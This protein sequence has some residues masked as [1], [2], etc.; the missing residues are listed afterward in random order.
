MAKSG[1]GNPMNSEKTSEHQP[2][3]VICKYCRSKKTRKYGIVEG[4][5]RYYCNDCKR[6]FSPN[7]QTFRMKTPVNQVAFALESYYEGFSINKVRRLLDE[8]YENYPSSKTV[9]R[10]ITKYTLEA[11]KQFRDYYLQVG[12]LWELHKTTVNIGSIEYECLDVVDI[13]TGYLLASKLILNS[14]KNNLKEIVG[15][16]RA[17]AGK[18]AVTILNES[19][20]GQSLGIS[21]A[22]KPIS[23]PRAGNPADGTINRGII[24]ACKEA[25]QERARTLRRLKNPVSATQFIEGFNVFYNYLKQNKATESTPAEMAEVVYNTKSWLD[26]VLSSDPD[27]QVLAEPKA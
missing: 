23:T 2:D 18:T 10:W 20:I 17:K 21:S 12:D 13:K 11:I 16:A 4:I 26:I 22:F 15:K 5:Q 24:A 27:T 7:K 9:Y 8:R 6:K 1:I 14:E 19:I 25:L 3:R